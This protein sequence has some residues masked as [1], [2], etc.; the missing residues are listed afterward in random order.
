MFEFNGS[1]YS[2]ELLENVETLIS[3][4]EADSDLNKAL[5][6]LLSVP[7]IEDLVTRGREI[8]SLGHYPVLDPDINVPWPMV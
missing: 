5:T 7:E 2:E 8:V 1:A 4:L 6:Q 3:D